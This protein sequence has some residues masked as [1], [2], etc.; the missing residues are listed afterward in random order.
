MVDVRKLVVQALY[1]LRARKGMKLWEV[2][3][4]LR[5][6]QMIPSHITHLLS[7]M[8]LNLASF[9]KGRSIPLNHCSS[10]RLARL[11]HLR[12]EML[13]SMEFIAIGVTLR[14][15][16]IAHSNAQQGPGARRTVGERSIVGH[17]YGLLVNES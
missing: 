3:D 16:D 6:Q 17:Y 14:K 2:L 12:V 4:G 15:S 5:V 10:T 9:E 11:Q 1:G 8:L 13:F 7:N